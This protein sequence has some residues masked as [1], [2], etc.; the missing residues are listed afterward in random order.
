MREPFRLGA[1]QPFLFAD[2]RRLRR[3]DAAANDSGL[4]IAFAKVIPKWDGIRQIA[5]DDSVNVG[6][7]K[8]PK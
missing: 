2:T 4:F 3:L 5:A 6:Q 1:S 8:S 7:V